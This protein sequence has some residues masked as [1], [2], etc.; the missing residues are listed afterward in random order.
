MYNG[1]ESLKFRRRFR[2]IF[3]F[4]K[5]KTTGVP[6]YLFDLIPETSHIYNTRSSENVTIFYSRTGVYKYPFFPYTI[7]EWNKLDKN[8]QQFKTVL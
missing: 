1:F 7:L 5:V 3:N 8:I 4:Y 2:K 6:A